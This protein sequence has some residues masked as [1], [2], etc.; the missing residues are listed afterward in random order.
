MSYKAGIITA[1]TELKDRTSSSSIA[2][3]KHL[4]VN[5]PADKKWLNATFLSALKKMVAGGDLVQVKASYKLSADY[6][7]KAAAASKPK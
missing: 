5:L 4:Q 2:I 1:I 7:K 3:K 6:E